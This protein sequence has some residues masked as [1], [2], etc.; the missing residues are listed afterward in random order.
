MDSEKER[1]EKE[2]GEGREERNSSV[3]SFRLRE[4]KGEPVSTRAARNE[5]SEELEDGRVKIASRREGR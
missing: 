4:G 2:K 3:F 5:K 1:E